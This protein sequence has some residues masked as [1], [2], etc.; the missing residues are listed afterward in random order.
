MYY[1]LLKYG[2]TLKSE[3]LPTKAVLLL[4]NAPTH[5]HLSH[6]DGR[7][8]LFLPRIVTSLVQP[9]DQ[10]VTKSLK[11]SYRHNFLSEN[12]LRCEDGNLPRMENVSFHLML[13]STFVKSWGKPWPDIENLVESNDSENGRE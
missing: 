11:R 6:M 4:N 3:N 10:G 7:K 13:S 12:L 9:V 8:I 2:S 5:F 1:N